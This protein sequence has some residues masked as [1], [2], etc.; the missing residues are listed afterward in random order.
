[1]KSVI[2]SNDGFGRSLMQSR[3]QFLKNLTTST[4][5]LSVLPLWGQ[6]VTKKR[7]IIFVLKDDQRYDFLS[8]LKHPWIKTPNI[9]KLANNGI[10]FENAFVT[11]SLC[12]LSRTSIL[13]EQYARMHQVLDNDTLMNKVTPTFATELKKNGYT[14]AFIGKWHMG[15]SSDV[16]RQGFDHWV[17]FRGQGSYNDPL[18]NINDEC[19]QKHGY[20]PDI[21]TDEACNF[22]QRQAN[23][24]QSYCLYLSHKSIHGPFT[25]APHHLGRYQN[26]EVPRPDSFSDTKEAVKGKPERVKKQRKSW[27]GVERDYSIFGD[28][29]NFNQFFQLY[30]ECMLGVDDSIEKITNALH[31][32]GE[33]ENTVIIYFSDNGYMMGEYRLIDKRVMYEG[34]IRVPCFVFCPDLI[35]K[36]GKNK[37]F[38]LNIDLAPTIL[39]IAGIPKPAS[40]HGQSFFPILSGKDIN[41]RKDF[42]Y[43]YFNDPEAP[44]T[45]TTFGLRTERYSYMTYQGVWDVYELYDL[46]NDPNQRINLSGDIK[47]DHDYGT[48][49]KHVRQQKSDLY[50]LVKKLDDRLIQLLR[51]SGGRRQPIFRKGCRF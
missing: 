9:D 8:C 32:T 36:P 38:I 43:E 48:F 3:R 27:H 46:E 11:T 50:P 22:I 12:S 49:L 39:D 1:M 33:L 40:M 47:T 51:E 10:F 42:V 44:H 17:S 41:W 7:N 31:E 45:P 21:L 37:S 4:I 19:T 16:P 28:Y 29:K 20:T 24:Y 2:K 14:T 18:L 15:A 5:G 6:K 25:P 30:N 23:A 13:T 26:L 34:S 35:K